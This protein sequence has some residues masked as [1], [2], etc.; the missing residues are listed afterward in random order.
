MK[1]I[2]LILFTVFLNMGLFSCTPTAVSETG[3][4]ADEDQEC[5]GNGGDIPPPLP[6]SET[7]G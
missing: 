2:H 6:E 1:K 4:S 3:I 5:C 7:G